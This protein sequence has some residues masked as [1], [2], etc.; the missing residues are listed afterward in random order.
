MKSDAAKM[1][2]DASALTALKE[3]VEKDFAKATAELAAVRERG[4]GS[5]PL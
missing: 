3:A 2:Q 4:G 1:M 5:D